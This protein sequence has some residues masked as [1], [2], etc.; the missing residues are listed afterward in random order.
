MTIRVDLHVHAKVSKTIPF[1]I[2][3]FHRAVGRAMQVGLHGFAITEHLHSADYWESMDE[4]ARLYRY[5]DGLLSIAPGFNVLTGTELTV[6]DGADII[7]IGPIEALERFDLRFRRRPS[8]G[9]FPCLAEVIDPA[10]SEE[11]VLIG[12]HPT[13]PGKRLV[14]VGDGLLGQLDA[15]EVNGKDMASGPVDSEIHGWAQRVGKPTVGSSDA[16]LWPQVGVQRTVVPLPALTLEGLRGALA[17]N[18][19]RP[20]STPYTRRIVGMC[21]THKQLIKRSHLARYRRRVPRSTRRMWIEPAPVPV[22]V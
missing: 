5:K 8:G 14:E 3:D 1:R 19:V 7:V 4:L 22:G 16:H 2:K 10:R 21:Q 18:K 15:L 11:L 17:A 9:H 20:E 13:R 6:A 12:A